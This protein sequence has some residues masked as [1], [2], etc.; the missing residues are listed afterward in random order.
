MQTINEI[1]ILSGKGGTGKTSLAA[2]LATLE[3]N[4]VAAD[5]DV[6]AANLYLILHPN[7][8]RTEK[9]ISGHKA[10]INYD[11]CTQCGLCKDHCRFNAIER[12]PDP[13]YPEG[14]I[15][16]VETSCD[17]CW[18]CSRICPVNA[19]DMVP[20]DKSNWFLGN[21]RYGKM[22]HARLAPGEENSGKLVSVVREQ[23]RKTADACGAKNI[24]IDG[25][26]GTGCA[27]IASLT[28]ANKV[29]VVTEPTG[30]GLHDMKRILD[31]AGRFQV[32]RYVIINKSDLN[33]EIRD[34]ICSW[35]AKEG[36]PV[37]GNLPFDPRM[38]H[39]MVACKS[40]QEWAPDSE[41]SASIHK[42]YELLTQS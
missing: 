40:I 7:D 29:V 24:I 22:V 6:D 5:C 18:L 20:S 35:C 15:S 3:K 17:G 16:I 12:K 39:A 25:P 42:I 37:I 11:L 31:L 1:S 21:Y 14:K 10:V 33:T 2:A 23:A 26:P 38:V 27:A 19:I 36:I 28:G 32:K 4:T 34:N 30:T 9:Y 13:D 8:Y 41:I